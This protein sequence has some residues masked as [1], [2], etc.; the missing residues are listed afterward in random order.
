MSH[1]T[2]AADR[3]L[4]TALA[5]AAAMAGRAP[6]VHNTQPWRWTVLPDALE[7]RVVRER[8]LSAL[9]PEGRLLA[10]SCGAALHHARLALAAEGW[11]PVVERLPDPAQP[12]L[13][14]R[15]TNVKH[16][17][18]DPDA[19]HTVQCIQVRHTDRRPV[20]D[21]P[22]PDA[23]L[24]EIDRAATREGVHLQVLDDSQKIQLASAAQQA[25]AVEAGSPELR[26]EL[27][28][29][30]SRAGA[31]TGLPPEV[32]PVEAPQTTV[33]GR[34]FGQPGTLPVGPGHDRAASYAILW[35]TEDE[36]DSWLRAGEGLS[37]AWLTA[38]RL[39][40]SLVP[41][42]GVVEVEGTRQ[43]LRQMLSGLGFPYISMRLGRAD[44][45]H[46]GPPH[47]PRLDVAQ[48]VDTS[49]VRGQLP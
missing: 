21:E 24:E 27:A 42:S 10:V 40:V 25:A 46:A 15:L 7:L 8:H 18:A 2:P 38:T 32:L 22:I 16:T 13:L 23:A 28:Y 31:G 11:T 49:A 14:A 19:M 41:L 20:S 37:A 35:G 3:S 34:D 26:E 29:W 43:V 30:T 17:G 44:P 1:E 47:T 9:D 33:P 12:D 5:E 4:T 36:P 48:T 45:T 39:G 6:S